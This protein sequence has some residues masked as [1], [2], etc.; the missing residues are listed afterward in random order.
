MASCGYLFRF[1]L[2][3]GGRL[4]TG[5]VH[6]CGRCVDDVVFAVLSDV[7]CALRAASCC[8][9]LLRSRRIL[10][11]VLQRN[12]GFS[13]VSFEWEIARD[14]PIVNIASWMNKQISLS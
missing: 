10:V 7:L 3:E 11:G 6:V 1:F 2:R 14:L 9:R 4:Y 8:R 13:S 5:Y 12:F